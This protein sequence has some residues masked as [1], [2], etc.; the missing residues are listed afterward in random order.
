VRVHLLNWEMSL[1]P[2]VDI[3]HYQIITRLTETKTEFEMKSSPSEIGMI[4][5]RIARGLMLEVHN[6]QQYLM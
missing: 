4:V 1:N 2:A 6:Q 5:E 3:T